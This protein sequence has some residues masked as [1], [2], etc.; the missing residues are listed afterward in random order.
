MFKRFS[1]QKIVGLAILTVFVLNFGF[2]A[3]PTPAHAQLVTANPDLVGIETQAEVRKTIGQKIRDALVVGTTTTLINLLTFM[4]NQLAYDTAVWVASGGEGEVPLFDNRPAGDYLRYTGA[5]IANEVINAISDDLGPFNLCDFDALLSL[6]FG[7]RSAFERPELSADFCGFDVVNDWDAFVQASAQN[8]PDVD[9]RNQ[10][11]LNKISEG[12]DPQK[13]ELSV[14][15]TV[16][17]ETLIKANSDSQSKLAEFIQNSGFQPA[18][19]FIT[20]NVET[21][22]SLVEGKQRDAIRIIDNQGFDLGTTLISNTDALLQVGVMAGS[23]FTNTLLSEVANQFFEGLYEDLA[24]D[25]DPFDELDVAQVSRQRASERLS[26]LLSFTPLEVTD[27][28]LLSEFTSCPTSVRGT[29]AGLYNC[30]MDT[31]FASAVARAEAGSPVTVQEAIDENYLDGNWGLIPSTNKSLNQ[32]PRC[33]QSAYC[34]SNLIKLRKSRVISV[35]WELAAESPNNDE[36]DPVTL[37]E[38]VNGFNDCNEDGE[39]DDDH[40]WCHLIDPNW[41]LKFPQSECRTLAYGQFL[42]APGSDTRTEECVDVQSCIS[43]DADGN[44]TGGFGYCVREKNTW[45]FRG[46]ACPAQ[47]ASC[48]TFEDRTGEEVDYLQNT[49]EYGVCGEDNVG[50]LWYATDKEGVVQ[51]DESVVFDWPVVRNT[52]L[53]AAEDDAYKKRSYFTAEIETCDSTEAGCVELIERTENLSLN[54]VYNPS[55]EWDTDGNDWPDGWLATDFAAPDFDTQNDEGRAGNAAIQP[56]TATVYQYGLELSQGQF[57]T[58]SLYAKQPSPS[59]SNALSVSVFLNDEDGDDADITG[60][61]VAGDCALDGSFSNAVT[62]TVQPDGTDYERFECTFTSALLDDDAQSVLAT[63]DLFAG[64]V[65]IDDVQLEQDELASVFHAGYSAD[66]QDLDY[67]YVKVPPTYLGCTGGVDDPEECEEFAQVCSA[68]NDGCSLYTPTNGD[69]AVSA[70]VNELN[71]CPQEC[72]G[73]DTFKQEPTRYDPFGEFPVYFIP[74][75]AQEC[76]AEDV[77]C[78]E[79]TNLDTEER[80]YFT[81]L[82]ACVTESQAATGTNSDNEATFYTWEGSDVQGFQLRTWFLIES[83][84]AAASYVHTESGVIDADPGSAPCTH[85]SA[86]EDGVI[87]HD[88]QNGDSTLDTDSEDCDEHDD[89][90]DNPDCREFY[91][92][93]GEIH[94]RDWRETVTVNDMCATYRKSDVAGVNV[95]EQEDSCEDSGGFWDTDTNVCLYYGFSEESDTCSESANGCREYTGGRS[96]NSRVALDDNFEGDLSGW[97]TSDAT[98]IDLSNESIATDGHSLKSEGEAVWTH[99]YDEGSDCATEG[100]CDSG[101]GALGGECTVSEGQRVC[102]TLNNNLFEGKTY[103]LSFWAKGDGSIDVGFDLNTSAGTPEVDVPFEIDVELTDGWEEFTFGPINA[104]EEEDAAFADFEN[105]TTLVFL[106]DGSTEFFIDNVV[107]R[108]GEDNITVIRDSWVTPATCDET[109]LGAFSAQYHLGCRAYTDQTGDTVHLKSF[110]RLCDEDQVGCTG[111]FRTQQSDSVYGALYNATC[112]NI[113][114]NGDGSPDAAGSGVGCYMFSTGGGTA[115]DEASQRLCTIATNE[116]SCRFEL[117]YLLPEH[118]LTIPSLDHIVFNTDT[119]KVDADRDVYVVIDNDVL[120]SAGVAGCIE[121]GEPTHSADESVIDSWVSRYF[122]DDPDEYD[123]VLCQDGE[124]YCEEYGAEN[125]TFYFKDPQAHTCEYKT[126]I[127]VAGQKYDGWFRTGTSNFCYGD[128]FCSED[129]AV[130][131]SLDSDCM[132]FCDAGSCSISGDACSSDSDCSDDSNIGSCTIDDGSFVIAGEASGLWRN[133]DPDYDNWVGICTTEWSGCSEF[134][135]PLDIRDDEFYS[136][137]DG[138]AYHFIDNEQLDD[139]ASATGV[140]CNGQVSAKLGCTLFNDTSITTAK[141]NAS[142]TYISSTHADQLF[143]DQPFSLVNPI[144]CDDGEEASTITLTNGST[145]DLCA[146]RCRYRKSGDHGG[147]DSTFD[148]TDPSLTSSDELYEWGTACFVD[149]DCA[150]YE[151]DTGDLVDGT[152]TDT[153]NSYGG[154]G[155]GASDAPRLEDDTNRVL[156]VNRDRECSEWLACSS[157]TTV[158]DEAIQGYRQVCDTVDLCNEYSASGDAAFCSSWDADDPA[159]ILDLERYSARDV[160]WYGEEYAGYAIPDIY[161]VQHLEQVKISPPTGLCNMSNTDSAFHG[162]S[163]S[164]DSDCGGVSG[165]CVDKDENEFTLAFDAGECGGD[166]RDECTVG[167]CANS[168]APCADQDSCGPGEGACISGLCYDVEE[169]ICTN[170]DDCGGD[171]VC[172]NG[173]C[174]ELNGTCNL[175]FN[176]V[177][178]NSDGDATAET[179]FPSVSTK[180]GSCMRGSC[181]VSKEGEPISEETKEPQLCRAHPEPNSP[182]GNEVVELWQEFNGS[183]F[184]APTENSDFEHAKISYDLV[185]NFEQASLCAPG[186]DCECSYKKLTVT[187]GGA[188]AYISTGTAIADLGTGTPGI[189]SGGPATGAICD[190]NSDCEDDNGIGT[191]EPFTRVDTLYGLAGYCLENDTGRQVNGQ[192]DQQACATWL[193]VDQLSGST[194]LFAK[195]LSAGYTGGETS[196][197][198]VVWPYMTLQTSRAEAETDGNGDWKDGAFVGCLDR[199]RGSGSNDYEECIENNS[200]AG[201]PPGFFMMAGPTHENSDDNTNFSRTCRKGTEDTGDRDCPFVCVPENS[202]TPTGDACGSGFDG[203]SWE[204]SNLPDGFDY[205]YTDPVTGE[206]ISG[207]TR[208]RWYDG[209]ETFTDDVL[210]RVDCEASGIEYWEEEDYI[211]GS[212]LRTSGWMQEE[213]L[214]SGGFADQFG[215]T[216]YQSNIDF[217][218]GCKIT[219]VVD[220]GEGLNAA[221]YTDRLLNPV[222]SYTLDTDVDWTDYTDETGRFPFGA[223]FNE[224]DIVGRG[225]TDQ[226][227]VPPVL[228]ACST[229]SGEDL[230]N[231]QMTIPNSI[232]ACNTWDPTPDGI[233]LS[234]PDGR[235]FTDV[236]FEW[237]DGSSFINDEWTVDL[238]LFEVIDIMEQLFANSVSYFRYVQG[239]RINGDNHG[240]DT[241][242]HPFLP[243]DERQ[244]GTAPTV[245]AVNVDQCFGEFCREGEDNAVTLGNQNFGDH[246]VEGGFFRT[247]MKFFA[248][249]DKDQLPIRAVIIDWGDGEETGSLDSANY[250]KNHRGLEN[251]STTVS[252][253]ERC[254]N[255]ESTCEWGMTDDSCDENFFNYT[256]NYFCSPS[257]LNTL[258]ACDL[259]D[260]NGHIKNTPCQENDQCVFQP[261]VHIRDNWGWCAGFCDETYGCMDGDGDINTQSIITDECYFDAFPDAGPSNDPWVYY[262]GQVRITP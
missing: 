23:V 25:T 71:T 223:S 130:S 17:G 36:N 8:I 204:T 213:Y 191:C 210:D 176:C 125:A 78:D 57:Y 51:E 128:G 29:S 255:G 19:D 46:E 104:S 241:V 74:S 99:F 147:L 47:Y 174:A 127:T 28:N 134:Q 111:L 201:C 177:G 117:D 242:D 216:N 254:G 72:N 94:Y 126:D 86:T 133:G 96:G 232:D 107:L 192:Q 221:Q 261:R 3:N 211:G 231:V 50:C 93:N 7:L 102:G 121:V 64:N 193:P 82:R 143:G 262:D 59:T 56:G 182:F 252:I 148:P 200:E 41:V 171:D 169:D 30:V 208:L 230:G 247:A 219:A 38:V 60:T 5:S 16:M 199:N 138:E 80:E 113:D 217:Y 9:L 33:Y 49:L 14:G 48:L 233:N 144:T 95:G 152:C 44:C 139:S 178:A 218:L 97:D 45:Q 240:G 73:Y 258:P 101:V 123:T 21:P 10:A 207:T 35:G 90:F 180:V 89:I 109:E 34:H 237:S 260:E 75:S 77:G 198:A 175:A 79:F 24:L 40:P 256:H 215:W 245:W 259:A 164:S 141:Y 179:C 53:A 81:Y 39:L 84:L 22:A 136:T 13:N 167:Y 206:E 184:D 142:A 244:V 116:T 187:S 92:V 224:T 66:E 120:C 83:N 196:Y 205:D 54:V 31:S 228:G 6:R 118:V 197:C 68:Q 15:L 220:D 27:F 106:P 239:H 188:T 140:Q 91:D 154:A 243:W 149:D 43:E 20:G 248:A 65:W 195:Y 253:C 137:S 203:G 98:A 186:E 32:D 108:E 236:E 190:S 1:T 159:V 209:P 131:C 11:I 189:C 67:T 161:P 18:V 185:S 202:F 166:H 4:A 212:I 168:G 158:W 87:C 163:C 62:M 151:A 37:Q 257:D 12:W 114:S 105:A 153:A 181:I 150:A 52:A 235:S 234:E 122:L 112:N 26:N 156:K 146:Q 227:A 170:D 69:P 115:F 110:A 162:I 214:T 100:G 88:D 173:F 183:T 135:D 155:L 55:F 132:N 229:G 238:T 58:L 129:S 85:W 225:A 145:L 250:Y 2:F 124:L 246:D 160:T 61:S 226:D 119:Q 172:L 42:E 222:T 157:W 165:A 103:F 251:D 63:L 76:S 194:D 249:A 70:V